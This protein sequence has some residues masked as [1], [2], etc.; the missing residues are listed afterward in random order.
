[1]IELIHFL[2]LTRNEFS[3]SLCGIINFMF[4]IELLLRAH[5]N[6]I[7]LPELGLC[8]LL[9]SFVDELD[10]GFQDLGLKSA[11]FPFFGEVSDGILFLKDG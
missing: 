6:I 8:F 5:L 4:E 10:F 11:T 9:F 7:V 3:F 1:M 2:G